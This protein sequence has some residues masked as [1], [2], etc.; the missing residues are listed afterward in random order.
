MKKTVIAILL[1]A[2]LIVAGWFHLHPDKPVAEAVAVMDPCNTF[3][4]E[5]APY[6]T[7][8][9][10]KNG[11]EME[12]L[13]SFHDFN[14]EEALRVQEAV[15][16]G[17]KIINVLQSKYLLKAKRLEKMRLVL[18]VDTAQEVEVALMALCLEKHK[19]HKEGV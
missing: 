6:A 10:R 4:A 19:L 16:S 8:L 12:L 5:F 7:P 11:L 14:L 18:Q 9:L 17:T 13:V 15:K 2:P 1:M 3:T